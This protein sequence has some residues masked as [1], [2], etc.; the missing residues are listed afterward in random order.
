[1]RFFFYGT[2]MD[3]AVRRAVLGAAAQP[4]LVE[5]AT[6]AGW[7]RC[8]IPGRS[9]PMVRPAAD[10][11]VDGLLAEGIDGEGAARLDRFEGPE[12]RRTP[13]DV[14]RISGETVTAWVYVA[15]HAGKGAARRWDFETW[16]R[17][18]RA[19][20]LRGLATDRQG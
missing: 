13:L 2:L 4:L 8:A 1:V 12:Y 7:Q 5:P 16:R 17:Q 18:H 19:A 11:S 10:E 15:L 20:M 3:E 6:L 14:R 9:Y